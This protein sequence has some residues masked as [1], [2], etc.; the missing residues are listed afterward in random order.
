MAG[1]KPVL[2]SLFQAQTIRFLVVGFFNTAISYGVY[3]GC[4]AVGFPFPAA[5]AIAMCLGL[6]VSFV[7]QGRL[8]FGTRGISDFPRFVGAWL[9]IYLVSVAVIWSIMQTG[10][11][12]YVA[13]LLAFPVTVSL[14]FLVQKFFVF[15]E[16]R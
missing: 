11:S 15:R 7:T 5:S 14:S 1:M 3:A 2:S 12:A 4:L 16:S 9:I 13:G 8:V 6:I 10:L